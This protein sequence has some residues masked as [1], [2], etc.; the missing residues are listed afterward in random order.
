L[1]PPTHPEDKGFDFSSSAAPI[2]AVSIDEVRALFSRYGLL[3]DRVRFLKGW[4]RDT[5]PS[6]PVD[7]IALLRLDGDLYE[8]TMDALTALYDKVVDG[9]F[10]LVDDYGDF[11]P[12]RKAVDEFR[13]QRG[14]AEPL[15]TVDWSGAYWRKGRPA[16]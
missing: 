13:Q 5:L 4:F 8:S 9:G 1:P 16:T 2:L 6:A 3:D 11:P 12:C 7:T 14:I 10:V 15:L